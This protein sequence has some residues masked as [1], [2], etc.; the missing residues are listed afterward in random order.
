M[1]QFFLVTLERAFLYDDIAH[2]HRDA[3]MTDKKSNELLNLWFKS[4]GLRKKWFADKIGVCQ[5]TLSNWISGKVTPRLPT[6]MLID[7]MTDGAVPRDRW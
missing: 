3:K 4:S 1:Q 2:K 7:H 6:R 5:P